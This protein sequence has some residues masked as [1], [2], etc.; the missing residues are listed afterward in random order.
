MSAWAVSTRS[1]VIVSGEGAIWTVVELTT[2]QYP[3][4]LKLFL[5]ISHLQATPKPC[6]L[7]AFRMGVLTRAQMQGA[8]PLPCPSPC[9]G[10]E[11]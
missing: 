4:S 7:R 9:G 6:S 8:A 5:E 1:E 3:T 10:G 11:H 2:K